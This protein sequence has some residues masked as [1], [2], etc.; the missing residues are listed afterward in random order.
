MELVL[1]IVSSYRGGGRGSRVGSRGGGRG[2]GVRS[3][4]GVEV[5]GGVPG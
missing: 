5:R 3:L 1:Q 4:G 2:S